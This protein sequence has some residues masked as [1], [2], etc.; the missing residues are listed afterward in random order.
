[1][2]SVAWRAL[3]ASCSPYGTTVGEPDPGISG[4]V[5]VLG[6]GLLEDLNGLESYRGLPVGGAG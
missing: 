5:L 3:E 4:R 2:I 6:P 1:M